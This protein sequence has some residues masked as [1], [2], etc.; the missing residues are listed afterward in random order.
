M[1]KCIAEGFMLRQVIHTMS[2]CMP[3]LVTAKD[4]PKMCLNLMWL[5]QN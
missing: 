5:L 1:Q 3:I 2:T 4:F